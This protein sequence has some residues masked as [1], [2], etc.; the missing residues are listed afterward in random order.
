MPVNSYPNPFILLKFNMCPTVAAVKLSVATLATKDHG[1][2]LKA[3]TR[4]S[5]IRKLL[6]K[7]DPDYQDDYVFSLDGLHTLRESHTLWDLDIYSGTTFIL[8]EHHFSEIMHAL[9]LTLNF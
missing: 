2:A 9:L 3:T 4:I 7:V 8:S 5:D 1:F 6:R